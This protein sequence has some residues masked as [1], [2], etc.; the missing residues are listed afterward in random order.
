[1]HVE[2]VDD[3]VVLERGEAQ[4]L[5]VDLHDER[6]HA[7]E[8][9]GEFLRV[10]SPGDPGEPLVLGVVVRRQLLDALREEIA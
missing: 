5:A 1:M 9:V 6:H 4:V 7:F 2:H 3:A 8:A 10:L